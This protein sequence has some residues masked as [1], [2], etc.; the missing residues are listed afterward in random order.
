MLFLCLR[1][2]AFR[3]DLLRAL[4]ETSSDGGVDGGASWDEAEGE[5]FLRR[6][7][8]FGPRNVGSNVLARWEEFLLYFWVVVSRV[9]GPDLCLF[10]FPASG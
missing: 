10:N 3:E 1:S 8:A 2:D 5:G 7:L 9:R 4:R 6:A